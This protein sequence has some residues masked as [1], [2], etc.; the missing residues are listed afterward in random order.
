MMQMF[1]K[2]K[3]RVVQIQERMRVEMEKKLHLEVL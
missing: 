2:L 1:K 3:Y